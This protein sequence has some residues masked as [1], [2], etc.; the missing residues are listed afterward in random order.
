MSNRFKLNISKGVLFLS[1]P[2]T[3]LT[4]GRV[5]SAGMSEQTTVAKLWLAVVILEVIVGCTAYIMKRI[6]ADALEHEMDP[7]KLE[8]ETLASVHM[9]D[10][11]PLK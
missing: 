4:L 1:V 10:K 5:Q 11:K 7:K 8:V 9:T 2:V 3:L 6:Y